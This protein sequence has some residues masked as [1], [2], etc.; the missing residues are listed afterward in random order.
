M[1]CSDLQETQKKPFQFEEGKT[2]V[3]NKINFQFEETW[4]GN[5]RNA[6]NSFALIFPLWVYPFKKPITKPFKQL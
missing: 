6:L 1:R 4:L 2:K 3:N 5:D